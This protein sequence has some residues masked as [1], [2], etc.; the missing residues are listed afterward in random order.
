MTGGSNAASAAIVLGSAIVFSALLLAKGEHIYDDIENYTRNPLLRTLDLQSI[1]HIVS[2]GIVLRVYEPVS[3]VF[4][5]L[6]T[7][8]FD[9]DQAIRVAL[10]ANTALHTCN[11][12]LSY[13]LSKS[14]LSAFGVNETSLF[15]QRSL[16]VSALLV[17]LHPLRVEVVAWAS[18]LPYLLACL[19]SLL[20]LLTTIKDSHSDS[21][22]SG[23]K[24][25]GIVCYLL[26]AFSKVAASSVV[27]ASIVL[28]VTLRCRKQAQNTPMT[29]ALVAKTIVTTALRSV[30]MLAIGIYAVYCAAAA[31]N[32]GTASSADRI[33][34]VNETIVRAGYMVAY[35][36]IKTIYPANLTP[37]LLIPDSISSTEHVFLAAAAGVVVAAGSTCYLYLLS[38]ASK[39]SKDQ[40]YLLLCM[41]LVVYILLMLPTLGLASQHISMLAADRYCYIPMMSSGSTALTLVMITMK[42]QGVPEHIVVSTFGVLGVVLAIQTHKLVQVWCTAVAL[43]SHVTTINP[44]DVDAL[45]NFGIALKDQQQFALAEAQYHKALAIEPQHFRAISNLGSVLQHQER[46][47]EAIPH[48]VHVIRLRPTHYASHS[49]LAHAYHA[50]ERY[51]EADL[52]YQAAIRYANQV[53]LPYL[54]WSFGNVLDASQEHARA[55]ESWNQAFALMQR[56]PPGHLRASKLLSLAEVAMQRAS[57]QSIVYVVQM[58]QM[59]LKVDSTVVKAKDRLLDIGGL[60]LD[61]DWNSALS[62]YEGLLRVAPN[63]PIILK[64]VAQQLQ[65]VLGAQVPADSLSLLRELAKAKQ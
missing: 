27:A 40:K 3:L 47:L 21:V 57:Q 42:E 53:D 63:D 11:L 8:T 49:N 34:T 22:C 41:L 26:A 60:L 62:L 64:E 32:T 56:L 20:V 14:L 54:W 38:S 10:I 2:R 1:S 59:V 43:W 25:L 15:V 45:A 35:S 9:A 61:K 17:G 37:R 6:V 39:A 33:L 48:Y 19:F 24:L 30:P 36:F 28:E 65:Q 46:T 52:A 31:T 4:K 44:A 29:P 58:Y 55:G 7:H 12:L 5:L 13:L 16:V 51:D 50:H 23:W 18:C